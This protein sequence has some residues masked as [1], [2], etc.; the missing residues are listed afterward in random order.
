[1]AQITSELVP[2][3]P[4]I[5]HRFYEP[6]V[7]LYC[8]IAANFK[9]NNTKTPDLETDYESKSPRDSFR[10]FVNKL[11][12][13]CDS[14]RGGDTITAFAVLQPGSIEYRFASNNRDRRALIQV[15]KYVTM[16]LRILGE[17]SDDELKKED[18]SQ[19]D[20]VFSVVLRTVLAF[21]WPR[22]SLYVT[23][24][25]QHL[26]FCMD[27]CQN[28]AS[29]EANS[30]LQ[31]LFGLKH[32]VD[33]LSRDMKRGA[34]EDD[35]RKFADEALG[36]LQTIH[37]LYQSP[38]AE[39]LREKARQDRDL[40]NDSPWT[41]LR[42]AMGR[43]YSYYITVKVLVATR[44]R[45]EELFAQDIEVNFVPS[46]GPGDTPSMR[47]T[48]DGIA[49]R[50]TSNVAQREAILRYVDSLH[51]GR[52][53]FDKDL[54]DKTQPK[55]FQPIVHAEINLLDSILREGRESDERPRFYR[56]GDFGRYIG[57]SK[58]TCR[59]CG[60]YFQ[61]HPTAGVD[62]RPSHQ[63]L[64]YKWRAPDVYKH[65]GLEADI[66]RK[67]ILEK[68]L[69]AIR[70][71][72]FRV[73]Q[74]QAPVRKRHDSHTSP[75]NPSELLGP[76]ATWKS[77]LAASFGRLDLSSVREVDDVEERGSAGGTTPRG[78]R[79]SSVATVTPAAIAVTAG[80]RKTWS[81]T[82][83]VHTV[84]DEDEDGGDDGGAKL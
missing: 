7:F 22:I 78:S 8:I 11:G 68:M 53:R 35:N 51:V 25:R 4:S 5:R 49:K 70:E 21:N 81:R 28:D 15:K 65:D 14:E 13:I 38:F 40:D 45:R 63:N 74:D 71:E 80:E 69:N 52:D 9:N 12:Q 6:V 36:L 18:L 76:K 32:V 57:C 48:S 83:R 60:L 10:C 84:I 73:V 30:A 58:P 29:E 44:M 20:S 59:L 56:E 67:G 16:I 72:N 37:K 79:E 39:F 33:R 41:E 50:M 55:C 66:E 27:A 77:G 26:V 23:A 34:D 24:L 46:S 75:S 54:L 17:A 3:T 43:L 82:Q 61:S 1:M 31:D 2:L 64:Y 62:V 47:R 42:H 19:R